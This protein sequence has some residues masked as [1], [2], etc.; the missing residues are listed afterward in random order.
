MIEHYTVL[1]LF[2]KVD[3]I[4]GAVDPIRD[5]LGLVDGEMEVITS[6]AFPDGII[7]EDKTLQNQVDKKQFLFPFLFGLVGLGAAIVLAG[8]TQYIMNL[9]V[10]GKA[11]FALP[12]TGIIAYEFTLL[13]AVIGSVVSL[14][15]FA[16]IPNWTDRAYDPEISDG[17]LALLVKVKSREDQDKAA[18]MMQKHGAY[19]IKKG[20]NDF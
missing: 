19:K 20:E 1:G 7:I 12:P 17:A 9:N 5:E 14:L 6:A 8:G 11:M 16:G 18:S 2:S 13:F 15:Y 10:G 3:A 4:T